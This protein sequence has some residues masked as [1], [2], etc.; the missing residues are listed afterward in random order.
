MKNQEALREKLKQ[1]DE[2]KKI[3]IEDLDLARGDQKSAKLVQV[4]HVFG[5]RG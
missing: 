2:P 1:V 4:Q 3:K 5:V